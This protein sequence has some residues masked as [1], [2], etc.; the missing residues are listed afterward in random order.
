MCVHPD[1]KL[2]VTGGLLISQ[3]GNDS[4]GVHCPTKTAP[5]ERD[6]KRGRSLDVPAGDKVII[7]FY[8]VQFR[9]VVAPTSALYLF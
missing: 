9:I 8:A 4:F 3:G 6:I 1:S 2:R 7:Y 5:L